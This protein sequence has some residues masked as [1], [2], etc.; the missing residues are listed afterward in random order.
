M[1]DVLKELGVVLEARKQAGDVER[2][3]RSQAY[4]FRKRPKRCEKIRLAD[5]GGQTPLDLPE[6]D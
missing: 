2:F 5:E 1:S 6:I 4:L 3:T